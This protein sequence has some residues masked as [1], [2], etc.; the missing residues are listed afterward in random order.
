M[1]NKITE[2]F[3]KIVVVTKSRELKRYAKGILS[4]YKK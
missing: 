1:I 3:E 4:N 2:D